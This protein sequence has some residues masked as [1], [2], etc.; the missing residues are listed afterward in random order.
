M[1][2]LAHV[3][4]SYS[5]RPHATVILTTFHPKTNASSICNV[6]F[7]NAGRKQAKLDTFRLVVSVRLGLRVYTPHRCHCGSKIDEYGLHYSLAASAS[8]ACLGTDSSICQHFITYSSPLYYVVATAIDETAWS[9]F[10]YARW[11][12]LLLDATWIDTFSPW[13]APRLCL[14]D[15]TCLFRLRPWVEASLWRIGNKVM[16]P[17]KRNP[18]SGACTLPLQTGL[19]SRLLHSRRPECS[20][21][22]S[23]SSIVT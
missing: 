2:S 7:N 11:K 23:L 8:V 1:R 4:F 17:L 12:P 13:S 3:T 15:W 6:Q 20:A 5:A 10:P 21:S 16:L 19:A 9:Y 22:R 14:M 18:E